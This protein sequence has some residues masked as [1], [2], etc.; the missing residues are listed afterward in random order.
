MSGNNYSRKP[1]RP[2]GNRPRQTFTS[3]RPAPS[4]RNDPAEPELPGLL[5]WLTRNRRLL[6][7]LELVVAIFLLALA[8]SGFL[9]GGVYLPFAFGLLGLRFFY[10][11]VQHNLNI[12]FG[13]V[14]VALNLILLLGALVFAILGVTSDEYK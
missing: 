1:K 13:R 5:G 7:W 12:Q 11:Y 9:G 2:T 8:V 10:A 14:G 3:P 4:N 6:G